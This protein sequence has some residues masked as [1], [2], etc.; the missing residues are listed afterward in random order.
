[1]RFLLILTVF[2]LIFIIAF[3]Y[4]STWRVGFRDGSRAF[5]FYLFFFFPGALLA[6]VAPLL[7]ANSIFG[8][9]S[10][11]ADALGGIGGIAAFAT[12]ATFVRKKFPSS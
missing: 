3:R 8:D 11:L 10:F 9:H 12:F 6:G 2:Y 5:F 7:L 1:M 4:D